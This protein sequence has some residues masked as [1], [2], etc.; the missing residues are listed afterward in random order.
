MIV[1]VDSAAP[2]PEILARAAEVL[3]R[4]GLVAF[5]TETVYGLGA[6]AMD[7]A[8]VAGIYAAKG[9]PGYNPLI[10]HTADAEGA[11]ALAAAWPQAAAR[12]AEAFWPGP[13][14]LVVPKRAGVPD[15]VTAG[16]PSVALRVPAHPVAHALLR[17]AGLPVAAPSANRSTEVSPTTA[18]HVERGLG[19]RVDLILDGGPCPVGIES[20]VVSLVSAVP[21]LLRPG[22]V[23][24]D[25]LRRVVGEV[26]LPA[27]EPGGEAARPSPGMMDRH[28]APRAPLRMLPRDGRAEALRRAAEAGGRVGA[29]LLAPVDDARLGPVIRMPADPAGYAARL[30]AALHEMDEAGVDAILVDPVPDGG[31]WAGIRDRLRR[32]VTG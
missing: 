20:T 31:A 19:D 11:R 23:S 14:T 1:P 5:P 30:Y 13:L 10:V 26:A 32:A 6:H 29:L 18:R 3:R 4:G 2:E 22:S 7:P 16:L 27:A 25:E 21:T 17:T 24:V 8:A 28:Y 9:R 15:A 12:L